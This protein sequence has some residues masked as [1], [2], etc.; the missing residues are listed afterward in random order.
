MNLELAPSNLKL[1]KEDVDKTISALILFDTRSDQANYLGITRQALYKRLHSHPE[2]DDFLLAIRK[3][4]RDSLVMASVRAAERL[5]ELIDDYDP[6]I[7]LEASTKILDIS[8]V[9]FRRHS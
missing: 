3:V 2:I 9:G 7:S 5:V 4:T 8:G 1:S 6:K